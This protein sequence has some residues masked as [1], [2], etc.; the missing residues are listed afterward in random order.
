VK[1]PEI[2][3]LVLAGGR[4][5]RMGSDKGLISYHGKPQ[6]EFLFEVL[7]AC[8][9]QVFTSGN[10]GQHIP[11]QLNPLED[12]FDIKG[13]MN[14]ILTAFGHYPDKAWIAVAVDMPYVDLPVIKLLISNRRKEKL[15]TCF[16]NEAERFPEPLITLWEPA[17]FPLLKEFTRQDRISPKEFLKENDIHLVIPDDR[18]FLL[19]I[20]SPD[21]YRKYNEQ[22]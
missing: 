19:N 7:D 11:S 3:G 17:V 15:A 2:Y 1:D 20:N 4:S 22:A 5:T 6:R 10:A 13:P 9:G 18:K 14:G 21:E 12:Q 8:C 16:Y